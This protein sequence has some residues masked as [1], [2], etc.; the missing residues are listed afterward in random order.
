MECHLTQRTVYY[1]TIG[2][3]QPLITIS[4][5]PSDHRII[6]N[7]LEQI[8]DRR[9]GWQ[10]FYFDLPGTGRTSGAGITTIDQVLDVVCEFIEAVI[11][12]QS[13]TLLGL[14]VGGYLARGVVHRKP[15]LVNGLCLLVP[16]LSDRDAATLPPPVT[17]VKDPA[18]LAQL[19][20]EDAERLAGLA[21]VQNQEVVSWY[22]EVVV[23]ARHGASGPLIEERV[24]SFDLDKAAIPFD[25]PTLIAMGRQD[26]HVSY[27]DGWNILELYPRA[28]FAVLDRAGHALGVEQRGLFQALMIEWLDRVDE[29]LD[30][31]HSS[32]YS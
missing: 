30:F 15:E 32:A 12:S 10:R 11:P 3:G 23:P 4:G 26:S 1:Q 14:S 29:H 6:M 25:K 19:S 7:W 20:A 17:L 24:F 13:F 5:I 2:Q 31:L 28:T 27:Q 21:V 18:A 9:P 22:R 16:W 8:F